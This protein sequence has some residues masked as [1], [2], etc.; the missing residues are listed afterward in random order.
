MERL[1]ENK[2]ICHIVGLNPSD[3][4]RIKELCNRIKKY[5]FIDLDD[6]NNKILNSDEMNKM[7][8]SYSRLKKNKNDK[9]RDIDK[10]MTKYWEDNMIKKVY[11]QIPA[12]KKSILVGKNH[13][14]RILSKKVNFLISNKFILDNDIKK[15]VRNRIRYN[16]LNHQD[17]IING[18]FPVHFLDYKQQYKKRMTF[19]ESYTKSGYTKMKIEQ[20]IDILEI[21]ARNRIPGKGLWFSTNEPYNI[22]SKIHPNKGPIYAYIDPV[23]SLLGSFNFEEN[24]VE[25]NSGDEKVV[26][27]KGLDGKKMKKGRYLYYVTKEDFIPSETDSKYKYFTQNP[28]TVLEKE[29]ISNV[30]NKLNELNLIN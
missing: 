5:N 8:K 22:G 2:I 11:D 13:H 15:E 21:H 16:L 1:N 30:Y 3:K 25:Y 17:D 28:V 7:Y 29:K 27:L 9:Y 23:L 10:R 26:S 20:I 19:E 18:T 12:K 6:I 14:Y 4:G 24:N